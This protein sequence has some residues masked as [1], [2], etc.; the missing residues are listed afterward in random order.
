[1]DHRTSRPR[2][3][4]LAAGAALLLGGLAACGDDADTG[5]GDTTTTAGDTTTS[6]PSTDDGYGAADDG[7]GDGGESSELAYAVVAKDIAFQNE[8]TIPVGEELFLDNQDVAPHTLTA[9]DGSFDSGQVSAGEV[10]EGIA[11]PSE[12]GSYAFH[13]E[14]HPSMTG[15]LTVE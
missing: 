3:L 7:G 4:L 6:A 5:A 9:D 13:C 1:M 15:T 2:L 8:V 11:V 14:V 10:S 12:P